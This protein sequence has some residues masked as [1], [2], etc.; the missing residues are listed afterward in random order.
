MTQYRDFSERQASTGLIQ[1]QWT[2]QIVCDIYHTPEKSRRVE[3]LYLCAVR[4][5]LLPTRF[6][7]NSNNQQVYTEEVLVTASM[8]TSSN[9]NIFPLWC[10]HQMETFSLCAGNSPVTG[11]SSTQR[12]VTRSFD[13]FFDLCPKNGWVNNCEASDLRH[14]SAQHDVIV[15]S[16]KVH[17]LYSYVNV[18]AM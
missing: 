6:K 17:R 14:P 3:L 11:E 7:M 18:L 15:M 5:L 2:T 1:I 12:P 16:N 13:V 4:Y 10:R 9:G 8:M